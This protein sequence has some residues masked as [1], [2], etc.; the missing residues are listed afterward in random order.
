MNK[1]TASAT[2]A[3]TLLIAGCGTSEWGSG[4]GQGTITLDHVVC[5]RAIKYQGTEVKIGASE[6]PGSHGTLKIGDI[7]VSP[8]TI[9]ETSAAVEALDEEQYRDCQQALLLPRDQRGPYIDKALTAHSDMMKLILQLQSATTEQ[10]QL[11]AAKAATAS[12]AKPA[13]VSPIAPDAST[14]PPA[15]TAST[16]GSSN[17]STPKAPK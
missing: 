4:S 5:T 8:Q 16:T 6:F 17:S 15:P 13:A 9:R 11:A 14:S 7:D 3:V 10:Q 12:T 2:L 1:N